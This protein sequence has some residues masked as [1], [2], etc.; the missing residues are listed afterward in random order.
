MRGSGSAPDAPADEPRRDNSGVV[1]H[2]RVARPQQ[3]G[4]IAHDA[5]LE[6][7][8]PRPHHQQPRRIAR[9][10]GRSAI[11]SGGKVEIEQIGAHV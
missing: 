3:V 1:D 11:R 2:E 8:T 6:S 5:I 7:A 10:A 4:Q 9:R